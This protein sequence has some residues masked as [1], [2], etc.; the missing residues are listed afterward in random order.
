MKILVICQYYYPEQFKIN[1]ICENLVK[2]GHI[3]TVL[4]GLP[5]YPKGE[6]PKEY[7]WGKKRREIINGVDIIRS[8]ELSRRNSIVGLALNYGSYMMSASLKALF[9][10]KD[11]DIIF[12]YQLSPIT[13]VLPAVIMKKRTQKPELVNR[14]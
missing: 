3:V 5:N 2:E 13:M 6:I 10:K 9:L 1:D 14:K 4:T 7:R 12:S 8:F 11:Y